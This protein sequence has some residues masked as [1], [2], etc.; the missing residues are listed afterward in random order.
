MLKSLFTPFDF[1]A[2]LP[3][4][5][6]RTMDQPQ[7]ER[8]SLHKMRPAGALQTS[9]RARAVT[10][11]VRITPSR[12][13]LNTASVQ[14]TELTD[15]CL[16][17]AASWCKTSPDHLKANGRTVSLHGPM[18]DCLL[19]RLRSSLPLMNWSSGRKDN[20]VHSLI[21]TRSCTRPLPRMPTCRSS[22]HLPGPTG[23]SAFQLACQMPQRDP[24]CSTGA[25]GT[26]AGVGSHPCQAGTQI[27]PDLMMQVSTLDSNDQ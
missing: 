16:Q 2:R 27:L 22:G 18:G 5:S 26:R 15:I 21:T 7:F 3:Q 23:S 8:K 14:G 13:S 24:C 9:G 17:R 11:N 4:G 6:V 25:V 10:R 1:L 20:L 12:A 19:K